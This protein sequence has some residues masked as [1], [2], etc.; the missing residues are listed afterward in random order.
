MPTTPYR[1]ATR[2]AGVLFAL[3][4]AWTVLVSPA[5]ADLPSGWTTVWRDDFNGPAR[6]TL[7]R[8]QWLYDLG[9]SYPGGA[10]N[11][12]TGEVEAMTD[13]PANVAMDGAGNLAIT[14]IRD[15][16]GNWTS[17]RVESQRTDFGAGPGQVLRVESRLKLPDVS[18]AAAAGYWPAFWMLGDS[19]RAVAATNWPGVGEIDIMENINGM[20]D[21]WSTLHCGVINGG[22]CNEKTG[23]SSGPVPNSTLTSAFHTYAMEYD[24][25]RTPEQLRFYVD[26]A[27]VNTVSSDQMD[28]TTWAN[29]LHHGF[30]V[31]YDV[32]MGG[33]FPA[34]FGQPLPTADTASGKP[35]LIDYVA[36]SVK[37]GTATPS[38][39][40]T[41]TTSSPTA[42]STP[43]T[44]PTTSA[45]QTPTTS[46]S[47]VTG[48]RDAYSRTE[49]EA[50]DAQSGTSTEA[51]TDTGGGSDI[52]GIGNGDWTLY[53]NVDF[54]TTP[55]TQ[56][57]ARAAS[58][59]AG[60]V[61]GLVEV[62]LDS[63]SATPAGSFA[64]A[65][66]GGWQS[67]QTV[68]ANITAT[69]GLHDVYLTFTSGQPSDYV[70]LNWL[71]FSR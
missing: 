63:P 2:Y 56:L 40:T 37:G 13:S 9:H 53:R 3:A 41:T 38:P 30:F 67:W 4:L 23:L 68:P 49:A 65:N 59:A 12:G 55:A 17:G 58:G 29:A 34:A 48:T 66:T 20:A 35:M 31:I 14:A 69:T 45:S 25:S 43:T 15:S 8:A 57:I 22:P 42:T 18:G 32:A 44:A 60:G 62:R 1:R 36:V 50:Y 70:N 6:T 27:V 52:T 19:A 7:D 24:R 51:T 26:G 5:K 16:S 21:T 10:W 39:S 61:S 64:I 71:T 46:S 11:W 28:A 54:G 33:E 47:P